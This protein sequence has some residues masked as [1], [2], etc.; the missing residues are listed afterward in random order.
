MQPHRAHRTEPD[1]PVANGH[2]EE[3]CDG[4]SLLHQGQLAFPSDI[5]RLQ[6]MFPRKIHR[7]SWR[8]LSSP[9]EGGVVRAIEIQIP[10]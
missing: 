5:F 7:Q 6:S 4:L 8:R 3:D 1:Y 9:F 10:N 2:V